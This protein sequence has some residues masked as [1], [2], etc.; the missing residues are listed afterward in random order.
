LRLVL[1]G[2][3]VRAF[4]AMTVPRKSTSP[5]PPGGSAQL[6]GVLLLGG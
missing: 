6:Y 3:R 1:Y 4:V 2:A 5:A